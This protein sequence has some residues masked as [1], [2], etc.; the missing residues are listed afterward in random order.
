MKYYLDTNICIYFLKGLFPELPK[1]MLSMSPDD[2]KIPSI[3]E[4]ELL[5]GAV[6]SMKSEENREN[7]KRF[8]LPF[9]NIPFED[10]A[11]ACYSV[12]RNS[13][14]STGNIIGPNNLIIAATVLA[15]EGI[16]ITNNE[17]EFKRVAGLKVEN[18]LDSPDVHT[19]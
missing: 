3:V 19:K 16:L 17:K 9:E 15:N 18:W 6:K 7:V 10:K 5:Y 11:A 13:L 12:I 8:L 1:K 2:I 4:A 14:E